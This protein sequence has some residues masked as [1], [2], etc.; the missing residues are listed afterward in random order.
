MT[1]YTRRQR[2]TG[3]LLTVCRPEEIGADTSEGRWVTL[4][5]EHSTLIY[6]DTRQLALD[7]SGLDFCDDCRDN[8]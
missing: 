8:A 6:S 7:T 1:I 5:E 3:H 2:D 4:C